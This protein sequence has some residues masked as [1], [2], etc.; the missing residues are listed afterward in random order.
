MSFKTSI[1]W[2][3]ILFTKDNDSDKN[4]NLQILTIMY[5]DDIYDHA[6]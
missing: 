1:Y 6:H 2:I 4:T 3:P 5:F